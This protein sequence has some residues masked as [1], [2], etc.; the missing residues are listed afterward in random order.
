MP[1]VYTW[2]ATFEALPPDT[3]EAASFGALRIR[4]LKKAI[5]ERLEVDHSMAGDAEDGKHKKVT[6]KDLG[7][8]PT[9]AAG[10]GV[11]FSKLSGT[12][13]DLFYMDE[14]GSI[15]Q[16]TNLGGGT[17]SSEFP[18]GTKMLFQQTAAPAGWTK[19]VSTNDAAL[20]VVSGE[21]GSG[22]TLNF[23]AAFANRTS[24]N[25][26]ASVD[27][28]GGHTPTGTVGGTALTQGQLPDITIAF[29][30]ASTAGGNRAFN[31]GDAQSFTANTG[32]DGGY[33]ANFGA[34]AVAAD[35]P[36][37][38]GQTH[39]HSLTMNAVAAHTHTSP[40]HNHTVDMAVK[41]IDTIIASKD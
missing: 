20:R 9:S 19:V 41:Y 14:S 31:A 36:N 40:A 35:T 5:K 30:A 16:L 7:G 26:S 39:A 10:Q 32:A 34:G 21:V 23:S 25:T 11:L 37:T 22:G 6:L 3:G 1:F 18:A 12:K 8:N 29:R 17:K 15:Q 27:A 2:N 28:G 38:L 13:I 33:Q 24:S 4:D